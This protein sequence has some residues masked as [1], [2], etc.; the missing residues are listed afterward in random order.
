MTDI[1]ESNSAPAR[2]RR[3]LL[4]AAAAGV[5]TA[6]FSRWGHAQDYPTRPLR[7]VV[8]FAAGGSADTVARLISQQLSENVRQPVIVDNRPGAGGTIAA[9][10]VAKARPD[11]Y[12]LLVGDFGANI[13][14]GSLYP[15]LPYDPAKDFAPVV[16]M[17]TFPFVLLVNS[18]SPLRTMKD[19]IDQ[20]KAHPGDL[21]YSSA[22]IGS[23]SHLM[24]E[25]LN[26]MAGIRTE[27]IP[28]KG[29]APAVQAVM[30]GEADFTMVSVPTALAQVTA[31]RLRA[32]GVTSL[33][34]V[35]QLPDAPPIAAVLPGYEGINMHGL[36]APARTPPAIIARLNQEVVKVVRSPEVAKRLKELNMTASTGTPQEFGS[37]IMNQIDTWTAFMRTAN[38]RAE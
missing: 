18:A 23:S 10:F 7:L 24:P 38:I 13:V 4:L 1:P 31:G 22:G 11:G 6:P 15:K 17:V 29:G 36:H 2:S 9:D 37:L 14:A 27:H 16:L 35:P 20:A 34:P 3:S 19:L 33:T 28:Y 26:R 5:L 32:L 8:P 25:R 21:K 30:S 12:T